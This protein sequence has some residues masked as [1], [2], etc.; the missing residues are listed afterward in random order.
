MEDFLCRSTR[1]SEQG[2][3]RRTKEKLGNNHPPENPSSLKCKPHIR[4]RLKNSIDYFLLCF[5]KSNRNISPPNSAGQNWNFLISHWS[6]TLMKSETAL[7][8]HYIPL[9]WSHRTWA[10]S[11]CISPWHLC[12]HQT[13][14]AFPTHGTRVL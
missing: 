7:Y 3:L 2:K 9:P 4:L 11:I 8:C 12:R 6:F 10:L 13:V 1:I 14:P 5:P